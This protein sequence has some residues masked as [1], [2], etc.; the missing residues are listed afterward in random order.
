QPAKLVII[1]TPNNKVIYEVV[2][3][4]ERQPGYTFKGRT[5]A[6]LYPEGQP[7]LDART[8]KLLEQRGL[9]PEDLREAE[10]IIDNHHSEVRLYNLKTSEILDITLGH[11]Y[12]TG[13]PQE[14]LGEE[15]ARDFYRDMVE[16]R[17]IRG[18]KIEVKDFLTAR[19]KLRGYRD[20]NGR[21]HSQA[22]FVIGA[23]GEIFAGEVLAEK[24]LGQMA[25]IIEVDK[26]G[27]AKSVTVTA[28]VIDGNNIHYPEVG[29]IEPAGK[30]NE[31]GL[32][33]DVLVIRGIREGRKVIVAIVDL[34]LE[35]LE[36]LNQAEAN[37]GYQVVPGEGWRI[38]P[39]YDSLPHGGNFVKVGIAPKAKLQQIAQAWGMSMQEF[40]ARFR[41]GTVFDLRTGGLVVYGVKSACIAAGD[42]REAPQWLRDAMANWGYGVTPEGKIFV[43]STYKSLPHGDRFIKIGAPWTTDRQVRR[44]M[45][46][47]GYMDIAEFKKKFA[48]AVFDAGHNFAIVTYGAKAAA[49]ANEADLVQVPRSAELGIARYTYKGED[50]IDA[51]MFTGKP[52]WRIVGNLITFYDPSEDKFEKPILTINLTTGEEVYRYEVGKV[53]LPGFGEKELLRIITLDAQTGKGVDARVYLGGK[54]VAR[55]FVHPEEVNGKE[56]EGTVVINSGETTAVLASAIIAQRGYTK[57]EP[58]RR[59]YYFDKDF[60]LLDLKGYNISLGK[61]ILRIPQ[62]GEIIF[63]LLQEIDREGEV[64]REF[65]ITSQGEQIKIKFNRGLFQVDAGSPGSKKGAAYLVKDENNIFVVQ[66]KISESQAINYEKLR[67]NSWK[68]KLSSA[69]QWLRSQGFKVHSPEVMNWAHIVML[70]PENRSVDSSYQAFLFQLGE[71]PLVKIDL[72]K[73]R[74]TLAIIT[75][76]DKILGGAEFSVG[77]GNNVDLVSVSIDLPKEGN[78]SRT[79]VYELKRKVCYIELK[80]KEGVLVKKQEGVYNGN[81]MDDFKELVDNKLTSQQ[82]SDKFV[83]ETEEEITYG[84]FKQD[85][86]EYSE[87]FLRVLGIGKESKTFTKDGVVKSESSLQ[88]IEFS[89]EGIRIIY[90][91]DDYGKDSQGS[92]ALRKT[93]FETRLNGDLVEIGFGKDLDNLTSKEL[94]FYNGPYG[95]FGIPDRSVRIV[96]GEN[97]QWYILTI[98]NNT[99]L[100]PNTG[101]LT[102]IKKWIL[103]IQV[104]ATSN[105]NLDTIFANQ[106][107]R[108]QV[109]IRSGNK[110]YDLTILDGYPQLDPQIKPAEGNYGQPLWITF[111]PE[112]DDFGFAKASYTYPFDSAKG[113][114]S[115]SYRAKGRYLFGLGRLFGKTYT[116]AWDDSDWIAKYF[117]LRFIDNN[118]VYSVE[119]KRE[120]RNSLK[121]HALRLDGRIY[122]EIHKGKIGRDNTYKLYFDES[123]LPQETH[124]LSRFGGLYNLP[125]EEPYLEHYAVFIKDKPGYFWIWDRDIKDSG[126]IY[127]ISNFIDGKQISENASRIQILPEAEANRMNLQSGVLFYQGEIIKNKKDRYTTIFFRDNNGKELGFWQ[128]LWNHNFKYNGMLAHF[129]DKL[130]WLHIGISVLTFAFVVLPSII[131]TLYLVSYLNKFIL[132]IFGIKP[133]KLTDKSNPSSPQVDTQEYKDPRYLKIER[134]LTPVSIITELVLYLK[135]K[136]ANDAEIQSHRDFWER[137]IFYQMNLKLGC[138][139]SKG[140]RGGAIPITKDNKRYALNIFDINAFFRYGN[141]THPNFLSEVIIDGVSLEDIINKRRWQAYAETET[142]FPFASLGS[143]RGEFLENIAQAIKDFLN[144]R[145]EEENAERK[146]R[147]LSEIPLDEPYPLSLLSFFK[148]LPK[149]LKIIFTTPFVPQE[150]ENMKQAARFFKIIIG[151]SIFMAISFTVLLLYCTVGT[152]NLSWVLAGLIPFIFFTILN[153]WVDT[154]LNYSSLFRLLREHLHLDNISSW[155]DVQHYFSIL[156]SLPYQSNNDLGYIFRTFYRNFVINLRY[157]NDQPGRGP[158]ISDEEY[159]EL[160]NAL[161]NGII[162]RPE[163][164]E[165][166]EAIRRFFNKCVIVYFS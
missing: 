78:L 56:V 91:R 21:W 98:S 96:K 27:Q 80:D 36:A 8:I 6:Y 45:Q 150:T 41:E 143:P 39:T 43:Y 55:Y 72:K 92:Y 73:N 155:R 13:T 85:D 7:L 161:N 68:D 76:D 124:K 47:W 97:N 44:A 20:E 52:L 122:Y 99:Y 10:I 60:N 121:E 86:R 22:I 130:F 139:F 160:I 11:I 88:K 138:P 1:H 165:A 129:K 71:K 51:C 145:R 18:Q 69:I 140:Y 158:L 107:Y 119:E 66:Q 84:D 149:M 34:G 157:S 126:I 59:I 28:V 14:L 38:Y 117:N 77:N 61:R 153:F 49:R 100:D 108:S 144:R 111:I 50:R 118:L 75:K 33:K 67:H 132:K 104:E 15:G 156:E 154:Y 57:R 113:I 70:D 12:D 53:K 159:K 128:R 82:I 141:T 131:L 54:E 101:N 35:V 30:N 89:Q 136:N 19:V 135:R 123:E 63:E 46:A 164:L 37:W 83:P 133:A 62:E 151:E 102:F 81:V 40:R 120:N 74:I 162:I 114:N 48:G 4:T 32:D 58:L 148:I 116:A 163:T 24:W 5:L 125:K 127:A 142:Q 109:I 25:R 29:K 105:I 2:S 65:G 87:T 64:E 112:Y 110:G 134:K 31:L 146:N 79:L 94:I 17:T 103:P 137:V 93:S 95:R 166:Q 9:K 152:F 90:R 23:P 147:R 115:D 106:A 16:G 3:T 26:R 42:Y